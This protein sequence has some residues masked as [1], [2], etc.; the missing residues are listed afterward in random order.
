MRRHSRHP[1][2][3]SHR[4]DDNNTPSSSLPVAPRLLR[5]AVILELARESRGTKPTACGACTH[6]QQREVNN[7]YRNDGVAINMTHITRLHFGVESKGSLVC[8]VNTLPRAIISIV[9]MPVH[10]R[11]L[12]RKDR[13]EG[14]WQVFV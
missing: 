12:L 9:H 2:H 5:F 7:I 1:G 6:Q 4:T 13:R 11:G 10:G 14:W 3:Y 8:R